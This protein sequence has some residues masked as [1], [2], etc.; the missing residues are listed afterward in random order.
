M[1]R[2]WARV[3][4]DDKI[5]KQM[6]FEDYAP[7]DEQKFY[8]YVAEISTSLDIATPIILSK[9]IYHYMTFNNAVFLPNDFPENVDFDKFIL[10]EASKY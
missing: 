1:V 6:V 9:H 4:K 3:M 5:V 2:I 7:F 10:E 8:D